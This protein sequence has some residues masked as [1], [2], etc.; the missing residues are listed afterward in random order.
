MPLSFRHLL[1]QICPNVWSSNGKVRQLKLL[2]ARRVDARGAG[3]E[4]ATH[5]YYG[6]TVVVTWLFSLAHEDSPFIALREGLLYM[7]A[8]H[9]YYSKAVQFKDLEMKSYLLI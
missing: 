8:L 2:G 6:S 5:N 7:C 3:L 9:M 1:V 4:R